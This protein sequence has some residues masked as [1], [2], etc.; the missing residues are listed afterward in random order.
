MGA[1]NS[2]LDIL[3]K[4]GK[5][6]VTL[7]TLGLLV[8]LIILSNYTRSQSSGNY[9][10]FIWLKGVVFLL[11]GMFFLLSVQRGLASG[12]AIYDMSDVNLLF[13]SP[14]SPRKV[15]A[16]GLV[17]LVK[18]AFLAGFFIL[19]Q[20]SSLG[21]AFGVGFG[22]LLLIFLSFILSMILLSLM[23]LVVYSFTNGSPS[24]KRAVRLLSFALFLPLAGVVLAGYL[25]SGDPMAALTGALRSPV[26]SW[27]PAAGWGAEAAVALVAGQGSRAA[28]FVGVILGVSALL[29]LYIAFSRADYYEDVL[30]AT[31]T[32]FERK[33][34]ASENIVTAEGANRGKIRVKATGVSGAG[35]SALFFKHLRESSRV[36]PLGPLTW[37]SVWT[38]L[39]AAAGAFVMR[40]AGL[41]N[42]FQ[43]LAWMQLF[44]I[45]MGRGLKETYLHYIYMIPASSFSKILWSNL[46]AVFRVLI[47][48]VLIF[49]IAGAII[50]SGLPEIL[51]CMAGYTLFSM[52]LI[53]IN[54]LFMYWTGV[55]MSAGVLII[56]YT[57]IVIVV[58]LPGL[59]A[60]ML[61]GFSVG[62]HAG[63]L[64]GL[65]VLCAWELLAAVGCFALARG[66]LHKC[67]MATMPK[68]K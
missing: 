56:V 12:D 30:V 65:A 2:F 46:E 8:G 9:A 16:Y 66:V 37:A 42:V 51:L 26:F 6:I 14:V 45:G 67:D 21:S 48:S 63:L 1:K 33:R 13:V 19:F 3:R 22:G 11:L 17:R 47:E 68:T 57:L 28:L 23:S 35:A 61:L 62:G 10:D 43:I 64:L 44:L 41:W 53:G 27:T 38:V 49:S 59:A 39:G 36:N 31:E 15:L 24:R 29:G 7:L 52:L 32:A 25:Q 20:G 54:Y 18:T 4:P 50:G 55:D 40:Q 60:A 5:L 58:M 34:A